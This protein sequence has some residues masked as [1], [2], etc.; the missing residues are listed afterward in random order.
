MPQS[1][2]DDVITVTVAD[3]LV[4]PALPLQLSA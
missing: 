2:A 1:A 4:V 3:P